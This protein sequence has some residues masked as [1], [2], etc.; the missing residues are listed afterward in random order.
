MA[1][2]SAVASDVLLSQFRVAFILGLQPG[3]H[4]SVEE[5]GVDQPAKRM[6]GDDGKNNPDIHGHDNKHGGVM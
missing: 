2:G 4:L 5:E 1:L 3:R 6:A